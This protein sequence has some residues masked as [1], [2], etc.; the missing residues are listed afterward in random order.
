MLGCRAHPP[1]P[2]VDTSTLQPPN[3]IYQMHF[4]KYQIYVYTQKHINYMKNE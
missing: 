3:S 1:T 4:M 2:N